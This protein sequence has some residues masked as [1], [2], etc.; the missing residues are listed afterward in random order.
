MS[1]PY[2][3]YELLDRVRKARETLVS[4]EDYKI[5]DRGLNRQEERH[6]SEL[7]RMCETFTETDFAAIVT[8]AIRNYPEIVLKVILDELTEGE[9]NGR[10]KDE[11]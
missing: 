2:I 10:V 5:W 7:G 3:N 8:V 1:D 6:L 11:S 4:D 9:S